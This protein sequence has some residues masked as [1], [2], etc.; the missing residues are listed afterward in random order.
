MITFQNVSLEYQPGR[1]ALEDVSFELDS[2]SFTFI[3]GHS[4]AGKSSLLSLIARLTRP[5]SGEIQVG[6]IT[7]STLRKSQEAALRRQMGII[8]QDNQLLHDRNVFDN[9]ALPLVIGGYRY[10]DIKTRV[11]AALSRV[12]LSDKAN[13]QPVSLSGGEQQRVGI[14]RAVVARPRLLLA[15]EP[16]GNLDSEISEEIMRLLLHF[17]ASGVTV[18]FATH[19]QSLLENFNFPRLSLTRGRLQADDS[20]VRATDVSHARTGYAKR[21]GIQPFAT[22]A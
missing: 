12:G 21:P 18:L 15:D 5:S 11:S 8:F 9:V 6:N 10:S 3:C 2:G 14:A 16:T 1:F 22:P 20:L 4:G 7:Y 17:N 19:D 13:E